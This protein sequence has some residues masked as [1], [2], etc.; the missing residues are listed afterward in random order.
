MPP[1]GTLVY[2]FYSRRIGYSFS[3][4]SFI[5]FSSRKPIQWNFQKSGYVIYFNSFNSFA[6]NSSPL[7]K[8][9]THQSRNYHLPQEGESQSQGLR[10]IRKFFLVPS[11]RP[12]GHANTQVHTQKPK[13]Y[14]RHTPLAVVYKSPV[15]MPQSMVTSTQVCPFPLPTLPL[16]FQLSPILEPPHFQNNLVIRDS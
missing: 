9:D 14:K 3:A 13:D 10:A 8:E 7:S 2:N 15:A 1:T 5:S 11:S 12:T 6:T 4:L 16:S